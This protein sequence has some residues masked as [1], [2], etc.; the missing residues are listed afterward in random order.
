MKRFKIH[1]AVVALV[2][3]FGILIGSFTTV[4]AV[5]NQ[6]HMQ[7]ALLSLQSALSQ[8]NAAGTNKAGHRA[9]AINLV[10]QAISEVKMGI[11]AGAP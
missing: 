8:L 6:P 9:N 10:T 2:F 1:P 11:A 4:A 7:N 5:A 3:V